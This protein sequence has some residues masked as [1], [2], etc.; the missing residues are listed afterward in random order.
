MTTSLYTWSSANNGHGFYGLPVIE[1]SDLAKD[2]KSGS[3][4]FFGIDNAIGQVM[5]PDYT[6][7]ATHIRKLTTEQYNWV[8]ALMR[9]SFDI[10]VVS[11][12]SPL[13]TI[14]K[15]TSLSNSIQELGMIPVVIGCDHSTSYYAFKAIQQPIDYYLFFDA[16]L[17]MHW[18]SECSCEKC[19]SI[20][21]ATFVS[22]ILDTH[23]VINIGA[24]SA[25]AFFPKYRQTE[26]LFLLDDLN[27]LRY[28]EG[29]SVY[30][31]LDADVLDPVYVPNVVSQ[32]PFGLTPREL[33]PFFEWLGVNCNIVGADLMELL[34][35]QTTTGG[36]LA[37]LRSLCSLFLKRD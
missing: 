2:P 22:Y 13:E 10:G 11:S 26:N 7:V 29:K 5:G 25:T 1:L 15:L 21:H 4:V 17:D 36:E 31:S 33:L 32:E 14:G 35:T 30:V 28:L 27:D 24:R 8:D 12:N 20:S 9:P 6:G 23:K 3:P 18:H 37:L 19:K 16:H 34:P